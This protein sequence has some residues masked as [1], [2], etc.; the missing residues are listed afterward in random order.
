MGIPVAEM[1]DEYS[2]ET[3]ALG[4]Q[5]QTYAGMDLYNAERPKIVQVRASEAIRIER[6]KYYRMSAG[7]CVIKDEQRG[8]LHFEQVDWNNKNAHEVL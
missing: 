4:Q 8:R 6:K 7:G 1:K 3:L 5:I 2:K